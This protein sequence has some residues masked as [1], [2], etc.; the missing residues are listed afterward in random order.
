MCIW[1]VILYERCATTLAPF[2]YAGY[3]LL[4]AALR[5]SDEDGEEDPCLFAPANAPL[6][7]PAAKLLFNTI[8][9]APLNAHE[10]QRVGGIEMLCALFSRC[11][12]MLTPTSE[13]DAVAVQVLPPLGRTI[14]LPSH[15]YR[16][17]TSLT[18]HR[19]L[20]CSCPSCGP[21]SESPPRRSAETVSKLMRT[22]PLSPT[23]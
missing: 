19:H 17:A 7:V 18:P 10:L 13:S 22:P 2:K 16:I 15:Y 3:P 21:S 8:A 11:V 4:L 14:A 1:Q 23:W 9:A 6:L 5:S 20:R 12:S